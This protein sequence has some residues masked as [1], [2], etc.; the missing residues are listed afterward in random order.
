MSTDLPLVRLRPG[1]DRRV[2]EGF[3]W[4]FANELEIDPAARNIPP[5]ATVRLADPR[6]RPLAL[7]GFNVHS[8]IAGRVLSLD[9]A[10]RIDAGFVR[11]RLAAALSYR[12]RMV[13]GSFYRLVHAEADGLP[14][15]IVDRCGEV[16]VVQANTAIA[17]RLLPEITSA[18][19]ELLSPRAIIGRNDAAARHQEGLPVEIR[20]LAGDAPGRIPIEEAG[21]PYLA[22]PMGGQKTGWFFD[23]RD[24]RSLLTGFVRPG[25]RMLD[26]YCHTGGFSL[27][28][29]RAGASVLGIDRSKPALDLAEAAAAEAG[30]IGRCRFERRDALEA[31]ERLEREGSRYDIVI[32]DPPSFAKNRKDLPA[33]LAAHRR[34]AEAAARRVDA[35]GL[36]FLAT[37]SHHLPGPEFLDACASGIAAAKRLSR[38]A[39]SGGAAPDHPVHP[40]LPETAYLKWHVFALA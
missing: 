25:M 35:G 29:A 24:A 17:D 16:L 15:L 9:P 34:L 3:P 7:A 27:P 28:A 23:L 8:L 31:L 2:L 13:G 12:E 18:L 40:L 26:V 6:G 37:C 10:E 32:A 30:L 33:A 38:L 11:A 39:Y 14:G 5:G 4:V 20:M 22:D 1:K 19:Q 36:L 21:F